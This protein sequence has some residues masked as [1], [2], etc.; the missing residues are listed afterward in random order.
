MR[1]CKSVSKGN[2]LDDFQSRKKSFET[3]SSHRKMR[4]GYSRG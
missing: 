4:G 3:I 2:Y 1:S